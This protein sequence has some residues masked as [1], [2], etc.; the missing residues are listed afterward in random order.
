MSK[1]MEMFVDSGGGSSG[2]I[3]AKQGRKVA[4][5]MGS[6]GAARHLEEDL[7]KNA[8]TIHSTTQALIDEGFLP[9]RRL[10]DDGFLTDELVDCLTRMDKKDS[11]TKMKAL[12][13]F[14]AIIAA[15]ESKDLVNAR[16]FWARFFVS[17]VEDED[18]RVRELAAKCQHQYVIALKKEILPIL[19]RVIGPWWLAQYQ[20]HSAAAIASRTGLHASFPDNKLSDVLRRFSTE[21]LSLILRRIV[22][23]HTKPSLH[24]RAVKQQNKAAKG[25]SATATV[26]PEAAVSS[27]SDDQQLR[28]AEALDAFAGFVTMTGLQALADSEAV[29]IGL[30]E[31][32]D[33]WKIPKQPNPKLR[34]NFCKL[35][36]ALW[37][38]TPDWMMPYTKEAFKVIMGSFHERDARTASSVWELLLLILDKSPKWHESM[39]QK[40]VLM[41]KLI[42]LLKNGGFGAASSVYPSLL[43]LIDKL[44]DKSLEVYDTII[45]ALI[46]GLSTEHLRTPDAQAICQALCD[47]MRYIVKRA[48][49]TS[50]EILVR[51]HLMP[52]VVNSLVGSGGPMKGVESL[53]KLL[54]IW[55][56]HA[57][58]GTETE[59]A[60]MVLSG[61]ADK[62][63]Y[64]APD[65][66]STVKV[67]LWIASLVDA[68]RGIGKSDGDPRTL[69]EPMIKE[70]AVLQDLLYH[71]LRLSFVLYKSSATPDEIDGATFLTFLRLIRSDTLYDRLKHFL[72]DVSTPS[73][74]QLVILRHAPAGSESPLRLELFCILLCDCPVDEDAREMFTRTWA[75]STDHIALLRAIEAHRGSGVVD[76]FFTPSHTEDLV[77]YAETLIP[78]RNFH[79]MGHALSLLTKLGADMFAIGT[80]LFGKI[81]SE[82]LLFRLKFLKVLF[83]HGGTLSSNELAYRA[84]AV[85]VRI[86]GELDSFTD[87]VENEIVTLLCTLKPFMLTASLDWTENAI[88]D[89]VREI[90]IKFAGPGIIEDLKK[91]LSSLAS[92]DALEQLCS[93]L[94]DDIMSG[95]VPRR[96][97][98]MLLAV[99][100]FEK[101]ENLEFRHKY[102]DD[103]VERVIVGCCLVLEL[104]PVERLLAATELFSDFHR[105]VLSGAAYLSLGDPTGFPVLF[106]H[107]QLHNIRFYRSKLNAFFTRPDVIHFMATTFGSSYLFHASPNA[108][109]EA[110]YLITSQ[111]VEDLTE[112]QLAVAYS[113][114]QNNP[115]GKSETENAEIGVTYK[116]QVRD[117]LE[118]LSAF[119]Q[120]PRT[121]SEI[122]ETAWSKIEPM[123]LVPV[124]LAERVSDPEFSSAVLDVWGTVI[125]DW[126]SCLQEASVLEENPKV[127]VLL[128]AAMEGVWRIIKQADQLRDAGMLWVELT[129]FSFPRILASLL[130]GLFR[131]AEADDEYLTERH[132]L[133][134]R[135]IATICILVQEFSRHAQGSLKPVWDTMFN[136]QVG[137][138]QRLLVLN[139]TALKMIPALNQLFAPLLLHRVSHYQ[140][141]AADVLVYLIPTFPSSYAP[142]EFASDHFPGPGKLVQTKEQDAVVEPVK[143]LD[144]PAEFVSVLFDS[145]EIVEKML[146]EVA[147]GESFGGV[148][149]ETDSYTYL[150]GYLMV[151]RCLLAW[152]NNET[153]EAKQAF[154]KHLEATGSFI[155]L[156]DN[157]VRLL[158][159]EV[160]QPGKTTSDNFSRSQRFSSSYLYGF[161]ASL[162]DVEDWA[163]VVY[164]AALQE[165]P[166]VALSWYSRKQGP[167]VRQITAYTTKLVSPTVIA[168]ELSASAEQARSVSFDNFK[169]SVRPTVLEITAE[170]RVEVWVAEIAIRIPK[171]YPL[172]SGVVIEWGRT[173]GNAMDA[174]DQWLRRLR[175]FLQK[176]N[177]SILDGILEWKKNVDKKFQ[178]IES[179]A[180]CLS[181]VDAKSAALPKERCRTCKNKF[182]SE[183]LNRWFQ[184]Q[185]DPTCP[186]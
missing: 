95:V 67:S 106:N 158:P 109:V 23:V 17:F 38:K 136:L 156:L 54:L 112:L 119:A 78:S 11:A 7:L 15:R 74:P 24:D 177:G 60:L 44:P 32:P 5:A 51:S 35:L 116:N 134:A 166:M 186:L 172:G 139:T 28:I 135:L 63:T 9:A 81:P 152:I 114:L 53:Q 27:L 10:L 175:G 167:V 107:D 140:M 155:A 146:Q 37:E 20:M 117:R 121:C 145:S 64:A 69:L 70:H 52:L 138:P 141:V 129:E 68:A 2:K 170:Y 16:T 21:I 184:Q 151:W 49:R 148:V 89:T 41:P 90:F 159:L 8:E 168:H 84:V 18:P 29:V 55:L 88:I 122:G 100:Q 73:S 161:V 153:L 103:E 137:L 173:K 22:P 127:V 79:G 171:D 91:V 99:S 12:N 94:L 131:F 98:I 108:V 120:F 6:S 13:D 30:L 93:V 77:L 36:T 33:F 178:G 61:L 162:T 87:S 128:Q 56:G 113:F 47:C 102:W 126:I 123:R 150:T 165:M 183:C 180:I 96:T 164:T 76:R 185:V 163:H 154:A 43:V 125:I 160:V 1:D 59:L 133:T 42:S 144:P 45:S 130:D 157:L 34:Q 101:P 58:G 14:L 31:K 124:L 97:D 65:A 26:P 83:T 181:I 142:H 40:K 105:C 39:D 92:A 143:L 25:S 62:V 176:Q 80:R 179:C 147:L 118:A 174:W 132:P 71:I 46:Q 50:A 115:L 72:E 3:K 111:P 48:D 66:V 169:V 104:I 57:A 75:S 85:A 19:S 86:A 182:H 4:P 149:P 82:D 110:E